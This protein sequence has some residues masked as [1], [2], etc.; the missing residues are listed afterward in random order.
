[1]G[2]MHSGLEEVLKNKQL[3][4]MAEY[5]AA[6]A[7]GQVGLMVTGGIAPNNAGRVK[8]LAAK[9]DSPN[10]VFRHKIVTES[11]H[12]AG[13]KICLQILH[14]GR[15][16]YHHWAV[17]SSPIKSPISMFTPKALSSSGVEQTISDFVRC[18]ELASEAGYDGVE[19]WAARAT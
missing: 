10:E 6:R 18:A 4:D 14:S 1:M 2:S 15:Y 19:V 9:L 3:E 7:R 17:S 5:F 11:V 12:E 13:G 16:G 8:Y